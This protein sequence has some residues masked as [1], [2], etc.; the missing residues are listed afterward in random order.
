MRSWFVVASRRD[1]R[2][3]CWGVRRGGAGERDV[4]ALITRER[5]S[6][7]SPITHGGVVAH[8]WRGGTG[9][10]A[11]GARLLR[12]VDVSPLDEGLG[13]RAGALN[14]RT[15]T[16]DAIDAALVCLA[17]DGDVLLTSD[18]HDLGVLAESAGT[19][20]DLGPV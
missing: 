7:R 5:L 19:H 15:G 14:G 10:Q 11:E 8:V 12:G 1:T 16:G 9:R 13:R 2:L 17:Y 18:P 4:I 6:G 20:I 3:G